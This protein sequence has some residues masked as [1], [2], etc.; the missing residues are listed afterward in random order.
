[1]LVDGE[2]I[3][4]FSWSR[5]RASFNA[6]RNLSAVDPTMAAAMQLAVA[7]SAVIRG[8]EGEVYPLDG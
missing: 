6:P 1:M 8:D 5:G 4:T 7:L 3:K 2:W